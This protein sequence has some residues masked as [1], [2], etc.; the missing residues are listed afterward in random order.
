MYYPILQ[1][2]KLRVRK[3]SSPTG[4]AGAL[5]KGRLTLEPVPTKTVLDF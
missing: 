1:M 4:P 2:R 5:H 3:Q